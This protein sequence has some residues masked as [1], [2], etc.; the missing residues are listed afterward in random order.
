[1]ADHHVRFTLGS[2]I[3][4]GSLDFL[5]TGV[6]HDLVLLPPSVPVDHASF[7]GFDEHV[8]DLDPIGVEGESVL[9]SPAES[10][11]SPANV[12]SISE[13]M[14]GLCLHANEA[15]ASGGVRPHGFDHLRLERQLDAILGPRP[16][17]E[18]LHRL[19]SISAN[20]LS[21][22]LGEPLL[23]PEISAAPAQMAWPYGLHNAAKTYSHLTRPAEDSS[24]GLPRH[25]LESLS[26]LLATTAMSSS[27][28]FEEDD[29]S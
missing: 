19:R 9:P 16:S 15:R 28:D 13:S 4:F 18:D 27:V 29:G 14:V 8:G 17:Q 2:H 1:M 24:A 20:V 3:P 21:Q 6:D 11:G 10:L 26:E 12:N 7:P 22:L 5:C 25:H 23:S